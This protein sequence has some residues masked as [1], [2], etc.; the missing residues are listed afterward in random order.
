M[1]FSTLSFSV[2][3]K[4]RGSQQNLWVH[5]YN[6]LQYSIHIEF[7]WKDKESGLG[8]HTAFAGRFDW[9]QE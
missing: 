3:K 9:D 5:N 4:M 1:S 7:A 8:C 6:E 2:R